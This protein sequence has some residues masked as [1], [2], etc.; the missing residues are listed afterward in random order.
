[1]VRNT[2]FDDPRYKDI[3]LSDEYREDRF[4]EWGRWAYRLVDGYGS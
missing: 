3:V 1:M 4:W 2:D